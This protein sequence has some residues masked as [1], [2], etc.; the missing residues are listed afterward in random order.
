MS[1]THRR[2]AILAAGVAGCTAAEHYSLTGVKSGAPLPLSSTTTN[3]AGS[4]LLA[5]RP[6]T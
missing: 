3:L 4:V 2:A 1:Q 5:L 6:T